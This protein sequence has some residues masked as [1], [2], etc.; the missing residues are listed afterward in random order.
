MGQ[1]YKEEI[2]SQ[3]ET[4][5]LT[6]SSR[7]N[8]RSCDLGRSENGIAAAHDI[9]GTH[10]STGDT[11]YSAGMRGV[12]MVGCFVLETHCF[13]MSL[14]GISYCCLPYLY[15]Q[16]LEVIPAKY[17]PSSYLYLPGL[18]HTLIQILLHLPIVVHASHRNHR[19]HTE[20]NQKHGE[21]PEERH[22]AIHIWD[23]HVG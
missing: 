5:S 17:Y 2:S 11:V 4:L 15:I 13:E 7:C 18:N 6:E 14:I 12:V 19:H 22:A 8:W 3:T 1:G 9:I 21:L 10:G 23:G 16:V 20:D